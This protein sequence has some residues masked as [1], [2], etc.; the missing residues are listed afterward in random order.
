MNNPVSGTLDKIKHSVPDTGN[1][2][3][4]AASYSYRQSYKENSYDYGKRNNNGNCG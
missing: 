1:C 4:V 2:N 3:T